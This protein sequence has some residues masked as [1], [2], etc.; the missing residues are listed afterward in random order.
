MRGANV[1]NDQYFGWKSCDRLSMAVR[2]Q[3]PD[4]C[5]SGEHDG[6]QAHS[7]HAVFDLK[8][9]MIWCTKYRYKILRGRVAERA[10]DLIRQICQTREVVIVRGAVHR[11]IFTCYYQ[12]RPCWRQRNWRNTSKG[13]RAGICRRNFRNCENGTGDSTC[14]RAD[15]FA[16]RWARL[17]RQRSKPIS[18]A[19]SGTKTIRASK[20]QRPPSLEPALS[21]SSLQA[22]SAAPSTFSRHQILPAFSR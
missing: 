9:H 8:Y 1:C 18:K 6:V 13:D 2:F 22:A 21:R 3:P 19:K 7:A 15:T 12:R 20:S 16:R 11:I 17:T 4:P 10:R 14:G 5:E